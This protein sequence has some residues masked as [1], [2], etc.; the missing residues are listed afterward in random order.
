MSCSTGYYIKGPF[1]SNC[2]WYNFSFVISFEIFWYSRHNTF[3]NKIQYIVFINIFHFKIFKSLCTKFVEVCK[4]QLS[5]N[6]RRQTT[7]L[8]SCSQCFWKGC[9]CF[10]SVY[11]HLFFSTQVWQPSKDTNYDHLKYDFAVL[12]LLFHFGVKCSF[13]TFLFSTRKRSIRFHF[14]FLQ[15]VW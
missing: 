12:P 2:I 8:V 4:S 10:I 15:D 1:A 9:I 5:I 3:V 14:F 6:L 11:F 7:M 13:F